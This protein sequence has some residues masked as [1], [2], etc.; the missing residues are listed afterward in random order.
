MEPP[1]IISARIPQLLD[2]NYLDHW[3]TDPPLFPTGIK[4]VYSRCGPGV[5]PVCEKSWQRISQQ[6]SAFCS[7]TAHFC[8]KLF[9]IIFWP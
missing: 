7:Q 2:V 9:P 4:C 5:S 3:K 1:Y 8:L 6:P